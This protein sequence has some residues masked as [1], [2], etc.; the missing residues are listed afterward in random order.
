MGTGCG[1]CS[2]MPVARATSAQWGGCFMCDPAMSIE[3][4]QACRNERAREFVDAQRQVLQAPEAMPTLVPRGSARAGEY[5]GPSRMR[6]FFAAF[7]RAF[8]R[9]GFGLPFNAPGDRRS[10]RLGR[11]GRFGAPRSRARVCTAGIGRARTIRMHSTRQRPYAA[12]I[13]LGR[14]PCAPR[15]VRAHPGPTSPRRHILRSPGCSTSMHGPGFPWRRAHRQTSLV[16]TG[17]RSLAIGEQCRDEVFG[18]E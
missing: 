1:R 16:V 8:S 17:R 4:S 12:W 9:G 6:S 2:L 11:L 13:A 10:G 14:S 15:R 3:R 5:P 18:V 7:V